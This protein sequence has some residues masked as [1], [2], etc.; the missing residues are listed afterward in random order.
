M[1]QLKSK[2]VEPRRSGEKTV[3]VEE[4]SLRW[5][6]LRNRCPGFNTAIVLNR[7]FL[8][9]P[10]LTLGVSSISSTVQRWGCLGSTQRACWT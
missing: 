2:T 10:Y 3:L 7:F 9:L 4:C 1:K 8:T 5:K 6:D